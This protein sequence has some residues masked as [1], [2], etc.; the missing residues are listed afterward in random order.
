MTTP[1]LVLKETVFK[2]LYLDF[3]RNDL[4][5]ITLSIVGYHF[6][7]RLTAIINLGPIYLKLL[8]HVL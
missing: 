8:V 2:K 6:S 3:L 7:S 4:R 5:Q 1:G